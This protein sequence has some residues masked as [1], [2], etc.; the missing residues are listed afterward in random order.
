M[1]KTCRYTYKFFSNMSPEIFFLHK[2][3]CYFF[4]NLC[5]YVYLDYKIDKNWTFTPWVKTS[6]IW[7][8]KYLDTDISRH[9]CLYTVKKPCRNAVNSDVDNG[10]TE[11]KD[12]GVGIFY[13]T[14]T[15]FCSSHRCQHR[16]FAQLFFTVYYAVVYIDLTNRS[17]R[18]EADP[19]DKVIYLKSKFPTHAEFY[20]RSYILV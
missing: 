15:S 5:F 3:S 20:S 11:P 19:V 10:G 18:F 16:N 14:P 4:K 8:P 1:F 12:V 13:K 9:R 17:W 2:I 7:S 6:R